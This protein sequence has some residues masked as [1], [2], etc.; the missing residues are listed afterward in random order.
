MSN[1][2]DEVAKAFPERVRPERL[3]QL[4]KLL[5]RLEFRPTA[6]EKAARIGVQ[7]RNRY[8]AGE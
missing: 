4:W 2:G 6:A 7:T 3:D 8:L 1:L 5:G